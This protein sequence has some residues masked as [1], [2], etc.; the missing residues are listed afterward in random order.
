MKP[1]QLP[2]LEMSTQPAQI[3]SPEVP[4]GLEN[5][6]PAPQGCVPAILSGTHL[7]LRPLVHVEQ[8][9]PQPPAH[10]L[11]T[12]AAAATALFLAQWTHPVPD[13]PQSHPP[14]LPRLNCPQ[15]ILSVQREKRETSE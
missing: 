5:G 10:P 7:G 1:L 3:A 12:L 8:L 2:L 15:E 14:T 13:S 6:N 9:L 4:P 11:L